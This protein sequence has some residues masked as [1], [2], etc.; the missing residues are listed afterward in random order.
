MGLAIPMLAGCA[1]T[2][3]HSSRGP[4]LLTATEMDRVTVGAVGAIAESEI[5]AHA[6]PPAA[7]A[8]GSADTLAVSSNGPIAGAPFLSHLSSN[9]S[10][11][12][13]TASAFS[14]QLA[15]TSGSSHIFVSG[16][17]SWAWGDA[18]GVTIAAGGA[19]NQARISLQLNGFSIG[20]VTVFLG[21]AVAAACCAA[22]LQAQVT[23]D[24]G[25][26]P[27]SKE[28]IGN[29]VSAIPGQLQSRLDIAVVA[30]SLPLLD[31]G[32]MMNPAN[33]H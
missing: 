29:P 12:E 25:G 2:P 5:V 8:A 21:S 4:T 17:S 20:P 28:L 30:S 33:V 1:A 11:A 13:A 14:G 15:E 27:F 3:S 9:Y 23:A 24:G 22:M 32:Q 19:V 26:G 18:A 16:A 7:Q 6:L 31:P 10:A